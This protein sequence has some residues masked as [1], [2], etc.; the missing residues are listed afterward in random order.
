MGISYMLYRAEEFDL[1]TQF[2]FWFF[3]EKVSMDFKKLENAGIPI[4][5]DTLHCFRIKF[6]GIQ[7]TKGTV[8]MTKP[9]F[10]TVNNGIF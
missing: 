9:P 8:R 4:G 3:W 2:Q 10:A 7:T 5:R 1:E 6:L